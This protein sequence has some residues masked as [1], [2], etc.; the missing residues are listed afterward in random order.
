MAEPNLMSYVAMVT[1]SIG[2]ITGIA[3]TIMG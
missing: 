2:A 1:G 3:G